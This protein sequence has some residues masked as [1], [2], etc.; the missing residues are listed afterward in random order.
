MSETGREALP[1]V[2]KSR[3]EVWERSGGPSGGPGRVG[4]HPEG[5]GRV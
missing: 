2:R 3:P 5:L 4:G 1:K